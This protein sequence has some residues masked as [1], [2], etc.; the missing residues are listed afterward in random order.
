MKFK[1]NESHMNY[2]T[3][4]TMRNGLG[5]LKIAKKHVQMARRIVLMED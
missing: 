4:K 1:R 2:E 5:L 3:A